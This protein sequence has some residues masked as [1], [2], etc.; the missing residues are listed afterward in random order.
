MVDNKYE[1]GEQLSTVDLAME[2]ENSGK[3]IEPK[4]TENHLSDS[5]GY[6]TCCNFMNF[7]GVAMAK[8]YNMN[9]IARGALVMSNVFLSTAFIYY[10]SK[11][12]GCLDEN[13]ESIEDCNNKV[14]GFAPAALV[15]N[16]AVISGLLSA[17]LMPLIGAIVDYTRYRRITG[18]GT[19]I[20]IILIQATQIVLFESTW[21]YML[22]LQAIAGFLYQVLVLVCYAYLPDMARAVGQTT[23]TK[24][25][26]TFVMTQF[27]SQLSF[28]LLIIAISIAISSKDYMTARIS[29]AVNVCWVGFAFFRGWRQLPEMPATHQLPEGRSII[30][31]GFFQIYNTT[32]DINKNY[33]NSLRWFLLSIVFAEATVNAF[34]SV[35]V[36][37]LADHIGMNGT[38]VGIFYAIVLFS[39][40]P[41]SYFSLKVSSR[42]NPN[43][44]M[45]LSLAM[46]FVVSYVGA[47]TLQRDSFVTAYIWGIFVG[48]CLGWFYPAENLFF[49][50][51]LPKGHEAEIAGFFV[52]STQILGWL[53]PLLFSVLVDNNISQKFGLMAVAA[54]FIP[55]IG[56]LFL[57]PS[58]PEVLAEVREERST[59]ELQVPSES[60]NEE[61]V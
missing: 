27:S 54:F 15:T 12:A 34:T 50:M 43:H 36:V 26:S 47:L 53:P 39:S 45:K 18:I 28:L 11:E 56:F 37:F 3:E 2:N 59:K 42:L 41:G 49:S 46:L 4:S 48:F 31:Q 33:A 57:T 32:K 29:Q 58:W 21:Y 35:S 55:A 60:S 16:I 9:G 7:D 51:C 8:G 10:A 25:T 22:I 1:E 44:C 17:F 24:H 13:D 30:L 6:C 52:Y 23:M 14:H 38:Q 5:S 40:L 20:L 19:S 61:D